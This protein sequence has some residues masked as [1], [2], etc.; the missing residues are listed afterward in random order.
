M[1]NIFFR[2]RSNISRMGAADFK[3]GDDV[4]LEIIIALA[5][6]GAVIRGAFYWAL[7]IARVVRGNGQDGD[8]L[9]IAFGIFLAPFLL[10][11]IICP[12]S[13]LGPGTHGFCW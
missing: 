5:I 7:T 2:R 12:H 11:A 10:M 1:R 9:V 6:L 8:G 3:K 4:I 13:Y